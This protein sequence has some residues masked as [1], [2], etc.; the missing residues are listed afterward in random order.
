MK[1]KLAIAALL[2]ASCFG[3]VT[4]VVHVDGRLNE[5]SVSLE[6]FNDETYVWEGWS[7][8]TNSAGRLK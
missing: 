2:V 3:C 1:L 6:A 5:E 8:S 7:F 4:K